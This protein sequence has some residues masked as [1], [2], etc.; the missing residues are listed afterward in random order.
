LFD[1]II[2][3]LGENV[4]R[5]A[6]VSEIDLGS[7][8]LEQ[9][10]VVSRGQSKYRTKLHHPGIELG[11]PIKERSRKVGALSRQARSQRD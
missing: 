11:L 2:A 8:F 10:Q 6:I 1:S 3:C 5:G 9:S 7:A 4:M